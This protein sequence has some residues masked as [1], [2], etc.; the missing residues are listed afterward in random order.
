MHKQEKFLHSL[1]ALE[2]TL[3]TL[4]RKDIPLD[5][6]VAAGVKHFELCYESAWKYLKLYLEYK[7]NLKI[8][9]PKKIFRECFALRIIDA[10]TTSEL[11]DISEARNATVHDYDEEKAKETLHRLAEYYRTLKRLENII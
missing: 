6:L 2:R 4:L 10:K 5:T 8:D 3:D 11:L 1:N 7:H 9:S